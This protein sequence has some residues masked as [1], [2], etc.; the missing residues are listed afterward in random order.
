[1][2][3]YLAAWI[4]RFLDPEARW[5]E[6]RRR[7]EEATF[8]ALIDGRPVASGSILFCPFAGF[9]SGAAT[10]PDARG[11]GVFRALVRARWEEA[12]RRGTPALVVGAGAM[13]RPI[14]AQIGF[15]LVA[16]TQVLVD[17][18]GLSS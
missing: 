8:L 11:R 2:F 13:S 9:L 14:L 4:R 12:E 10:L 5:Q 6:C 15:R 17:G 16:E 1:M 3:D 18:S 7:A